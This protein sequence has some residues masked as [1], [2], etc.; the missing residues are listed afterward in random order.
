MKKSF[1]LVRKDFILFVWIWL[2]PWPSLEPVKEGVLFLRVNLWISV[3]TA[4]PLVSSSRGSVSSGAFLLSSLKAR[5]K[6][7]QC[8]SMSLFLLAFLVEVCG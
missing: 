6:P 2:Y 5:L 3:E 8:L 1:N 7:A 4:K